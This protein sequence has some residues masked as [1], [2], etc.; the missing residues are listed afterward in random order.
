MRARRSCCCAVLLL[1][2]YTCSGKHG[3]VSTKGK[4]L[5]DYEAKLQLHHVEPCTSWGC[6]Y[7][8]HVREGGKRDGRIP[9]GNDLHSGISASLDYDTCCAGT[10]QRLAA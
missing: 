9:C 3:R 10:K 4:R 5:D 2:P 8:G 6:R 1:N 7:R